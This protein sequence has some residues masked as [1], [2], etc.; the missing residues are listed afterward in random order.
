MSVLVPIDLSHPSRGAV[1]FAAQVAG[2]LG[3]DVRLL[4]VASQP[5]TLDQLAQ[6]HALAEPLRR[7]GVPTRLRTVQGDPA[8]TICAM[9]D[10]HDAAWVIMGTRGAQIAE[11]G[12]G[13]VA[14]AVMRGCSRPVVAVRPRDDEAA[15]VDF[16]PSIL[17][18]SGAD[19]A[20]SQL[21][22]LLG[23]GFHDGRPGPGPR[24]RLLQPIHGGPPL[25]RQGTAIVAFDPVCANGAS[26][27]GRLLVE[28]QGRAV[29]LVSS[30][31]CGC[32]S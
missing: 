7:R 9:A 14:R 31:Q 11:E 5:P 18:S 1:A 10:R 30:L 20:P 28:D 13:S 8:Q 2:A 21:A 15:L 25:P 17:V 22:H 32:S 12:A 27:C 26:W 6:L 23:S 19:P 16:G 3:T 4:H 24:D 29:V